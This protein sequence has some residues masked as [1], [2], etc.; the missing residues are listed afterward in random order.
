MMNTDTISRTFSIKLLAACL[1]LLVASALGTPESASAQACL[2]P[3]ASGGGTVDA[4][5]VQDQGRGT[6]WVSDCTGDVESVTFETSIAGTFDV[7][8]YFDQPTPGLGALV[9]SELGFAHPGGTATLT[10][11]T[12]PPIVMGTE[13]TMVFVNRS[14]LAVDIEQTNGGA[15]GVNC[16]AVFSAVTCV[17]A[18]PN[19]VAFDLVLTA[20][21]IAVEVV[22]VQ[23]A[24]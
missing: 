19:S 4:G 23:V 20:P 2:T 16:P 22:A 15:A 14:V 21:E 12:P 10:F 13:Y 11:A 5:V 17:N 18:D 3:T 6:H 1:M 7:Y 24:A 9:G 8:L